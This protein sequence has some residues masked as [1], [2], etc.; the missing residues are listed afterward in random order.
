MLLNVSIIEDFCAVCGDIQPDCVA[1]TN[2]RGQ[3]VVLCPNC[4]N[5]A[6]N[7]LGPLGGNPMFLPH[8]FEEKANGDERYGY[9]IDQQGS[10]K[11]SR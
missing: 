1:L 3:T 11:R 10:S 8:D 5:S 2:H 9:K 6:Y 7:V 4:I